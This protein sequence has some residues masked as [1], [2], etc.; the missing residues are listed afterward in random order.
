M[1]VWSLA[2]VKPLFYF[3]PCA[4]FAVS[5]L[6]H[7]NV[8]LTRLGLL[9]QTVNYSSCPIKAPRLSLVSIQQPNIQHIT[10]V[11]YCSSSPAP[12]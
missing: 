6:R 5:L 10:L 12:P 4:S 9:I 8:R 1:L 2:R 7:L 3:V 11:L